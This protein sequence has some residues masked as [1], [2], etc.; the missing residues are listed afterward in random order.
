MA[1]FDDFAGDRSTLGRIA[2][3]Q[4]VSGM[5][6]Q[7]G[8]S[9]W[10]QTTL[11]AGMLYEFR[12]PAL[13]RNFELRDAQGVLLAAV[14]AGDLR[15]SPAHSGT[16]YLSF[17]G[18]A[19]RAPYQLSMHS[20]PAND[21]VGDT[22]AS[23]SAAALGQTFNGTLSG[24][25]DQDFLKLSVKAGLTYAVNLQGSGI[26]L[27][28]TD[29]SGSGAALGAAGQG[30]FTA[31]QDG[32][33]YLRLQQ[34]SNPMLEPAQQERAYSVLATLAQD[35]Y[36]ANA[37]GAGKLAVDGS[38][39]GKLETGGGDID[40]F[41]VEL[42]AGQTY[43]FGA[44]D[45]A[46]QV[47][48]FNTLGLVL[49]DA[50]GTLLASC[51]PIVALYHSPAIAYTPTSSGTYYCAVWDR[52]GR[53]GDY[54][55][56]AALGVPDD[57]PEGQALALQNGVA[58]RG[59]IELTGDRD[60]FSFA[61][62]A[63]HVYEFQFDGKAPLSASL[64]GSSGTARGLTFFAN[65]DG[66]ATLQVDGSRADASTNYAVQVRDAGL[67]DNPSGYRTLF[68]NSPLQGTLEAANDID[69][70]I[71]QAY[72]ET[73]Y[74]FTLRG[75]ASGGGSLQADLPAMLRILPDF[76]SAAAVQ[77]DT[78]AAELRL[79]YTATQ[80][81]NIGIEVASEALRSGSYT[82]T[83]HTLKSDTTAPQLAAKPPLALLLGR[84][85]QLSFNEA[86]KA[87]ASA[88]RLLD[89]DGS[90]LASGAALQV[91][92]AHDTLTVGAPGLLQPAH[93]YRLEL[94]PGAVTDLA[95]NRYTGPSSF[96]Y[97]T[98]TPMA[99]ASGGDDLLAGRGDGAL[100]DGGAG[101]DTL[102][103][104]G[105]RA[106]YNISQANGHFLVQAQGAAAADTLQAVER[107]HF[108]DQSIALDS[109]AV[110]QLYQAAF[111]RA[112]DGTGL[113]FWIAQHDDG[114]DLASIAKAFIGSAEFTTLYGLAPTNAEFVD[115][116][117]GNVLHRAGEAGG[118]AFWN[119]AL[120]NGVSR[121]EVLLAFAESAEN[122]AATAPLVAQGFSYLPW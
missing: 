106:D 120:A 117:Y 38:I 97:T 112:P 67:D 94:A 61:T 74:E 114:V 89:A 91:S 102:A 36:A 16:Y 107:L 28:M 69:A 53:S 37:A 58:Q 116:L 76:V 1:T 110:F 66:S 29:A 62:Q 115:Q 63:G 68:A 49:R 6:E 98:P 11:E 20:K 86:I 81:G 33:Y 60:T 30:S 80:T 47:G 3:D 82:L 19:T 93:S 39:R 45:A 121:A 84:S 59:T 8:D 7:N 50:G 4:P 111:N 104:S 46:G 71:F 23:A 87:D 64:S 92:V 108:A 101:I 24:L 31:L 2:V 44:S 12:S 95:G 41:G 13:S 79:R 57:V 54:Q 26:S 15:Y 25:L 83:V 85:L 109:T 96:G 51:D 118:V 10:F 72:N 32:D 18:D 27:Q 9:D 35:D 56:K 52:W 77:L 103:Y 100:I 22:V 88:M 48:P 78:S 70:F 75:A 17:G 43:W 105:L 73:T 40:W 42:Q 21:D 34:Q 65:A 122:V 99:T 5:L 113:G 119:Q 90:V 55:L 14:Q